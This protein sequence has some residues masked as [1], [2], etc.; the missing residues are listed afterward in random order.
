MVDPPGSDHYTG[1]KLKR[2]LVAACSLCS[3][4]FCQSRMEDE[5][6]IVICVLVRSNSRVI[7][8]CIICICNLNTRHW[9]ATDKCELSEWLSTVVS[10]QETEKEDVR[11]EPG[12]HVITVSRLASRLHI[13]QSEGHPDWPLKESSR[14]PDNT[15]EKPLDISNVSSNIWPLHLCFTFTAAIL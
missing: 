5:K 6:L 11:Q 14:H 7:W 13:Y 9:N 15:K 3:I 4:T 8:I 1:I 12:Q 10:I 2:R